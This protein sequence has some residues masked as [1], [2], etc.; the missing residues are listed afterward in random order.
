M[1]GWLAYRSA[2]KT[3]R[4]LRQEDS[5]RSSVSPDTFDKERYDKV[6]KEQTNDDMFMSL[7]DMAVS[8]ILGTLSTVVLALFGVLSWWLVLVPLGAYTVFGMT[9]KIQT[10]EEIARESRPKPITFVP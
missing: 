9:C 8:A 5:K 10:R 4:V 3:L 2:R 7:R 6:A 1:W